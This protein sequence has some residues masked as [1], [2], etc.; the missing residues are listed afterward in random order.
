MKLIRYGFVCLIGALMITVTGCQKQH[1]QVVNTSSGIVIHSSDFTGGAPKKVA[2]SSVKYEQ[3]SK[4][5]PKST[6][7]V[8][9]LG[10]GYENIDLGPVF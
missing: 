9:R 6:G 3:L 8:I 7:A 2:D 1:T 4:P 10:D 5:T